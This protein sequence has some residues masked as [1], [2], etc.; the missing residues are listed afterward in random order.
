VGEQTLEDR[1]EGPTGAACIHRTTDLVQDLILT[2]DDRITAD[3]D[4]HRMAHGSFAGQ[5][6]TA[7]GEEPA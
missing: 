3:G 2:D 7:R 5:C 4:G 1:I 6:S